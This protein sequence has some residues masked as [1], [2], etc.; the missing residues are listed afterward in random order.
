MFAGRFSDPLFF[1]PP[2]YGS[3]CCSQDWKWLGLVSN[4]HLEN[5]HTIHHGAT[6]I[7][8]SWHRPGM[9]KGKCDVDCIAIYLYQRKACRQR[10]CTIVCWHCF[11]IHV[12]LFSLNGTCPNC[13]PLFDL[14]LDVSTF[15]MAQTSSLYSA[16]SCP[17]YSS[18][19]NIGVC[20]RTRPVCQSMRSWFKVRLHE[21]VQTECQLLK[22]F[23]WKATCFLVLGSPCSPQASPLVDL[24]SL[25]KQQWSAVCWGFGPQLGQFEATG[26]IQ[27]EMAK[28]YRRTQVQA[29]AIRNSL[30]TDLNLTNAP[31]SRIYYASWLENLKLWNS[32]WFRKLWIS[33]CSEMFWRSLDLLELH[34]E[35]HTPPAWEDLWLHLLSPV[36]WVGKM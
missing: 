28:C 32:T 35:H 17:F 13:S 18:L 33:G 26:E 19:L 7:K 12:W 21:V 5:L 1:D 14:D 34:G 31:N 30:P 9:G 24:I 29:M 20:H 15:K 8:G 6:S 11:R 2:A 25:Q 22:D 4:A 3:G 36:F 10:R 16:L 27:Q 23:D